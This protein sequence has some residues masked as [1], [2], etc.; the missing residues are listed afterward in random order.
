MD[1]C[2]RQH[3]DKMTQRGVDNVRFNRSQLLPTVA[4][5]DKRTVKTNTCKVFDGTPSSLAN[6][7]VCQRFVFPFEMFAALLATATSTFN[8]LLYVEQMMIQRASISLCYMHGDMTYQ[9]I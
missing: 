3:Y 5:E 1:L 7:L 9:T 6:V 8:K 4:E 2:L